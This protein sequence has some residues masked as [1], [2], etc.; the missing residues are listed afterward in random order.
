MS[1]ENSFF[2]TEKVLNINDLK[3]VIDPRGYMVFSNVP[4]ARDGIYEYYGSEIGLNSQANKV[5]RFY[6][7]KSTYDGEECIKSLENIPVTD[8]HPDED[9][10]KNNFSFYEKGSSEGKPVF[11]N[12]KLIVPK[13]V[14][15][16]LEL[17]KKITGQSVRELSI[18][19]LGAYQFGKKP[20][21]IEEN[22]DGIENV[23]SIN[24]VAVVE[25]GKAGPQIRINE[26]KSKFKTKKMTQEEKKEE[27]KSELINLIKNL[28]STVESLKEESQKNSDKISDF[29]KSQKLIA[30]IDNEE[31]S[32]SKDEEDL[33]KKSLVGSEKIVKML[34]NSLSEISRCNDYIEVCNKSEDVF[35][36]LNSLSKANIHLKNASEMSKDIP[37]EY[38]K[39]VSKKINESAEKMMKS[40]DKLEDKAEKMKDEAEDEEEKKEMKNTALKARQISRNINK[41]KFSTKNSGFDLDY[42]LEKEPEEKDPLLSINQR[43]KNR[44]TFD[45]DL[46]INDLDGFNSTP[47]GFLPGLQQKV[48]NS[49]TESVN[50]GM[51]L[52]DNSV[53]VDTFKRIV[54]SGIGVKKNYYHLTDGIEADSFIS[55]K[56]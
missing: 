35:V 24:H 32:K 47:R 29:E 4:I 27:D 1:K 19:F 44:R 50:N 11:E 2:R 54:N 30:N 52:G 55:G 48:K 56:S 5:F 42:K 53:G 23:V 13:I 36:S 8:G 40:S 16:S 6:R 26:Q 38:S 25:C 33:K 22:I 3:Y 31:T 9:V 46:S 18:G 51:W 7:D 20:E 39:D 15:K 28:N 45:L 49:Q 34:S 12:G 17:Q 41:L 37:E 43:T 21:K 10:D 14:I